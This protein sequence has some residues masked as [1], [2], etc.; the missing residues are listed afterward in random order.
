[1]RV[2][3]RAF[4][5][6][7]G[8]PIAG[9]TPDRPNGRKSHFH[10]TMQKTFSALPAWSPHG[11]RSYRYSSVLAVFRTLAAPCIRVITGGFQVPSRMAFSP[12]YANTEAECAVG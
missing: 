2:G 1:M 7:G 4:M 5:Q 10:G 3:K 11:K 12:Q 8:Q 6:L 9:E